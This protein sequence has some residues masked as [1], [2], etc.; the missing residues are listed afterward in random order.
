MFK[1][2]TIKV[3][4]KENPINVDRNIPPLFTWTY[5]ASAAVAQKS[6][7]VLVSARKELLETNQCDMWDSGTIESNQ[8]SAIPYNGKELKS[9][10]TYYVKVVTTSQKNEVSEKE[11]YFETVL[12][13]EEWIGKWVSIPDNFNGGTLL[14]RKQFELKNKPIK[15]ARAYIIG[16]GYHEFFLNGQKVSDK[17]LNPGVTDYSQ[18]VLYDIYEMD[19]Y[20][21]PGEDNV[22]GIEVGYGWHGSRK[23][24]AQFY[25]E[26]KDGE[27][28]ED[29]STCNHG[30][31]VSGSPTIDNSIYGGE[32]YDA[33]LEELTAP[34]WASVDFEPTWGNGWM[35]TIL[36]QPVTGKKTPQTIEPIR[37]CAEFKE[38]SRNQLNEKTIVFDIGQ[39]IAGWARIKV[40][41]TRGSSVQL[42]FAEGLKEDGTVNQLNL[43]SARCSDTYILKGDDIE[44][45][46]PRFTYHGFQFVEARI[47]GEVEIIELTGEHVHSDI[48]VTGHFEC[49]DPI[50]NHLH[51]MAVI[52][53]QNNQHSILTD[54]PQRDERFGWLNDVTSRVYQCVYNFDMDRIFNKVINDITETQ[55]SEGAIADTAPYYTGGQPADTTSASYLLLALNAYKYYG[56]VQLLHKEYANQ[57]KWVDYLLSRQD[58]YIMDYY[59]YADWVN[60]TT[61]EDSFTDGIYVSS[62]FLLW[63]L[64]LLS[65]LALIIGNVEDH[66][67]YLELAEA[68]KVALN[69]KYYNADGYYCNGTQ[70]ENA[71][72]ITLGVCLEENTEKVVKNI[73]DNVIKNNYHLTCGNQGYRHVFYVLCGYG[74][75]DLAIKVL[76]NPEYPGWG[77]MVACGATTVWERWES[78]M[79]NIMHSFD[80][81]MFGSY[82]AIF[83]RYFAGIRIDGVAASSI[84]IKPLIPESLNHVNC[85]FNSIRGEIVS[86]WKKNADATITHEIEIPSNSKATLIFDKEVVTFDGKAVN[87][88]KFTV[89]SGRYI[90]ITKGE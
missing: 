78:K 51:H 31:W 85:S 49:D 27:I 55:N 67:K 37:K 81:P 12:D 58:G 86:N 29:H 46:A 23:L 48:P 10:K 15:K 39:N 65:E 57:K 1:L 9:R 33:R 59:Y 6:Y 87:E 61:L 68:S 19:Q 77:Y 53:E 71:M 62:M 22:V 41:G 30:W 14:F 36:T 82:D 8:M 79:E 38:V 75:S 43:R 74:Y 76:K 42:L 11:S 54:C 2:N 60:P 84:I 80:H 25:I 83:Y 64:Q 28:Y 32:V 47:T 24:L 90:V 50:L 52:T 16:V 5:K 45:W 3:N 88:Q 34:H 40:K 18:T 35:Y 4:Y 21:N 73:V 69:K 44:E 70:T 26:Y 89:E 17:L 7:R 63:H 56:D 72:A 20:L 66:K 13:D